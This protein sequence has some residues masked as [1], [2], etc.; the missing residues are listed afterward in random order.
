MKRS[1]GTHVV[2]SEDFYSINSPELEGWCIHLVC[3]HGNGQFLYNG[4]SFSFKE[5]DIAIILQPDKVGE[6]KAS[7][8]CLV[9]FVAVSNKF[10]HSLLPNGHYGIAA[11]VMIGKN[12]I[13]HTD[14]EEALQLSKD[15]HLI[16]ER[17]NDIQYAFHKELVGCLILVMVYDLYEFHSKLFNSEPSSQRK[18]DLVGML[19]DM[20]GKGYIKRHRNV[21]FYAS[22][23]NVSPKYLSDTVRRNTGQSVVS[24]IDRHTLPMV[25]DYLNNTS[26]SVSQIADEMG[27][28]SVS[29]FSHYVQ[30]HL[31][32]S[33]TVFRATKMPKP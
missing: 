8:D 14:H 7:D 15:F 5:N 10:L 27:F 1:T 20:L 18:I 31:G 4:N 6:I 12:P 22:K 25:I 16:N 21:A 17:L 29:Y 2:Y 26:L 23:L 28:T 32:V 19:L 33:P 3:L 11:S 30:K 9:E 24:L 13:M